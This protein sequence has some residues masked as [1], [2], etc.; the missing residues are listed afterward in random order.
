MQ[1]TV[2]WSALINA[3]RRDGAHILGLAERDRVQRL[4]KALARDMGAAGIP[5]LAARGPEYDKRRGHH[6]HVV[7][8]AP[9]KAF[10]RITRTL[11]RLT[12]SDREWF[13]PRGRT[14]PGNGRDHKGV[15]ALSACRGWMVQR[16]LEGMS[17]VTPGLAKMDYVAKGVGAEKVSCRH[18]LSRE[19]KDLVKHGARGVGGI[20]AR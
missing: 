19:L 3:D 1:I 9:E 13:D 17:K 12:G 4:W 6:L 14:V 7:M 18:R 15:V 8:H 16:H 20:Q 11:E 2:T 10:L 5:W